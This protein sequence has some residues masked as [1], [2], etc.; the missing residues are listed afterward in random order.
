[1]S[2][3]NQNTNLLKPTVHKKVFP[4]ALIMLNDIKYGLFR[5]LFVQS[6][7]SYIYE[8]KIAQYSR[9]QPTV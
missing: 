7:S 5:L 4:F 8:E 3:K 2:L 6:L 9:A 1:M